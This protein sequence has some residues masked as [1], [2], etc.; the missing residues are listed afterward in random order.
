MDE[1]ILVSTFYLVFGLACSFKLRAC[2]FSLSGIVGSCSIW[3]IVSYFT[4]YSLMQLTICVAI[5]LVF[6][7]LSCLFSFGYSSRVGNIFV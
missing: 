6:Y 2:Y 7:F 4:L 5:L 3:A 1:E